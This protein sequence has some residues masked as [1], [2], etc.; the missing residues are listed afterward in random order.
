VADLEAYV[1]Y[2][3]RVADAG[4][5]QVTS[6]ISGPDPRHN[7]LM[8]AAAALVLFVPL[9]GLALFEFCSHLGATLCFGLSGKFRSAPI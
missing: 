3:A 2:S 8:V 1:N 7:A 4:N 9:P 5:T 6:N